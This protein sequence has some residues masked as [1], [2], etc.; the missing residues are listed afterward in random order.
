L[1]IDAARGI[2]NRCW[3]DKNKTPDGLQCL[4]RY[5][6]AKNEQTGRVS[7]D[8]VHDQWSHGADAF[9]TLAQYAKKPNDRAKRLPIKHKYRASGSSW[10][11]A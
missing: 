8:P 6:Y 1:A 3:F 7:K 9:L 10:M 5:H 2:L 11:S 4:R